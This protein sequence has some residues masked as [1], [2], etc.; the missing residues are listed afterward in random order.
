[1]PLAANPGSTA[2][3]LQWTASDNVS[4]LNRFDL[5]SQIGFGA[6]L[7]EEPDPVGTATEAW[8]IGHPG[9][10]YGF[11]LRGIDIAGNVEAFPAASETRATI[12]PPATLCSTPD[13]WDAGGDDNSPGKA[14]LLVVG[15]PGKMHNFCNPL[16]VNRL[17]DEDWGR[18][19]VA[20]GETYLFEMIPEGDMTAGIIELYAKNGTT[21]I[22]T[23]G[24]GEFGDP[25]V[26][27]WTSD[28]TGQVFL[29]LRHLDG[30]VAG[31]AVSYSLAVRQLTET[32]LPF[33]NH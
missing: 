18:V 12:P 11:R 25:A 8:Y 10:E 7:D 17:F 5:Q 31:N 3:R 23:A 30:R 19:I 22:S 29:R 13:S 27:K 24:S 20:A 14:P 28:R 4:G 1:L 9:I 6:W 21:L 2:V 16:D 15:A 32:Y 26:L 33:V